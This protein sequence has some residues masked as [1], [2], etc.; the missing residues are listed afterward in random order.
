MS[1]SAEIEKKKIKTAMQ[2]E[3][4]EMFSVKQQL[5]ESMQQRKP[6]LFSV[7]KKVEDIGSSGL[8]FSFDPPKTL[9][10]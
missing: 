7:F 3:A 1:H 9:K 6:G 4:S 2:R 5:V 8:G 10:I